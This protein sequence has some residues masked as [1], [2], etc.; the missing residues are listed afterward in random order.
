MTGDTDFTTIHGEGTAADDMHGTAFPCCSPV[1]RVVIDSTRIEDDSGTVV[2]CDGACRTGT[3]I[4]EI[5]VGDVTRA[6][7]DAVLVNQ[8][9]TALEFGRIAVEGAFVDIAGV[10]RVLAAAVIDGSGR[11]VAV[12]CCRIALECTIGA[13]QVAPCNDGTAVVGSIVFKPAVS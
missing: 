2:D 10:R 11:A 12:S 1:C 9:G 4:V 6:I 3:V 5:A 7:V 8:Q 13:F